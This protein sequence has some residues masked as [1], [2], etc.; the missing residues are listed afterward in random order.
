MTNKTNNTQTITIQAT[1]NVS[2]YHITQMLALGGIHCTQ[3]SDDTLAWYE[4]VSDAD[5]VLPSSVKIHFTKQ[6]DLFTVQD[7]IRLMWNMSNYNAL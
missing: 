3:K 7:V 1:E 5:V 4:Y 6:E 2:E